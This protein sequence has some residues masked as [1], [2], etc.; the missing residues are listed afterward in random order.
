MNSR[1]KGIVLMVA[2]MVVFT[3]LD[4][5]AKYVMMTLPPPVAVFF[6]YFF[7]LLLSGLIIIKAG[8]P[9]LMAARYPKLQ[10]AR[11]LMLMISTVLNFVA[12]SKLQLAQ[13][14][15]IF[16][17]I[18]LWVCALSVPLL[19][20]QVGIR[21]W[22]AVIAGFLGV[23]VIM[24]PGTEN[25][26]WAMLL[27]I[28][29]AFCGAIYNILTRKVGGKDRAET[30]LFYV[31]LVGCFAASLS[32]PWTWVTPQGVQ[33]LLLIFMGLAGGIGQLMLIEAHRKA[34]A[35]ALAPFVY[36][37]IIWM[38]LVG[39]IVF[40]DV[41]D[42]WT[43]AGAA[44]VVASGLFIFARERALALKTSSTPLVE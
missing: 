19:N 22:S 41:P 40:G 38:I 43:I 20:E 11:G 24:R 14:S 31:G 35:S 42:L 33:W 21:R 13:T 27:S 34:P 18:P 1:L 15:A 25:F 9:S 23:L 7:A 39:F 10:I 36:T 37:Q 8:E 28:G 26:H 32:L 44:I 29:S 5:T 6:R 17:T 30:S 16:F 12:I 4:S 2:S 3:M